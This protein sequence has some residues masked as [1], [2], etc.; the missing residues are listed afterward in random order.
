M[1]L[2]KPML[3]LLL[4][5]FGLLTLYTLAQVGYL[6]IFDYH[7]HS[8]A[9]WQVIADLVIALLL[10]LVWLVADA[11]KK[12]RNPWPWVVATLLTGSFGP[13]FYLLFDKSE[14]SGA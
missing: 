2:F 9:G 1:K 13:L 11:R 3:I 10:V 4:L 12:G 7:R 8:P 6:G 5:P 14:G